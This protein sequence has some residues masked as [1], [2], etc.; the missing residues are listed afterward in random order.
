[1]ND[2]CQNRGDLTKN[3]VIS[4]NSLNNCNGGEKGEN[5][6]YQRRNYDRPKCP[7]FVYQNFNPAPQFPIGF[8]KF[9]QTGTAHAV[10]RVDLHLFGLLCWAYIQLKFDIIVARLCGPH[11]HP[12]PPL[13]PHPPPL[14]TSAR[15]CWGFAGLSELRASGG[16]AAASKVGSVSSDNDSAETL[17]LFLVLFGVFSAA[18]LC[19][20]Y[21]S[22]RRTSKKAA[23]GAGA[24]ATTSSV[25]VVIPIV[26]K[27]GEGNASVRFPRTKLRPIHFVHVRVPSRV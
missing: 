27:L 1:M 16:F 21:T 3:K 4:G 9:G 15:V 26:G 6:D 12:L 13:C 7:N 20:V 25:K 22:R 19:A 18:V 14:T 8:N 17:G 10:C 24:G 5:N 2:R 23:A 11:P